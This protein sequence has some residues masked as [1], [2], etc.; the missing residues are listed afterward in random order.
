MTRLNLIVGLIVATVVLGSV[1]AAA[2]YRDS[3]GRWVF[4]GAT[5]GDGGPSDP[6]NLFFYPYGY[7]SVGSDYDYDGRIH[8][9]F[10][11]HWRPAW[12]NDDEMTRKYS[13]HGN[14]RMNFRGSSG[15]PPQ[16]TQGA[17]Y[18]PGNQAIIPDDCGNRYH[19]RMW[20]DYHAHNTQGHD[21]PRR[22]LVGGIHHERLVLTVAPP[23]FKGHRIDIDWDRVEYAAVKKMRRSPTS[24]AHKDY[25]GRS[26]GHCTDYR[27]KPVP[28]SR[29]FRRDGDGQ[30]YSDGWMTRISAGHCG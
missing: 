1:D 28:G 25:A 15:L 23:R 4:Y 29:G 2:H 3:K 17:G 16:N 10:D 21:E 13:C 11:A 14:Q 6:V 22:W 27:W 18:R 19:F 9:H 24:S 5:Y 26:G 30:I 20:A 12:E 8:T 7:A